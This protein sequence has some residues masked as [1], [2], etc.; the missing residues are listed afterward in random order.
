MRK[1]REEREKGERREGR[2]TTEK[3][4]ILPLG[5]SAALLVVLGTSLAKTIE[6]GGGSLAISTIEIHSALKK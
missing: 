1:E 5:E 3:K 4:E 6:T 2:E